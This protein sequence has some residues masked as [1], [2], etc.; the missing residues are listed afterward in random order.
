MIG[1][2][3]ALL[4]LSAF[5]LCLYSTACSDLSADEPQP[6]KAI[7][8]EAR[9]SSETKLT[10][11][12]TLVV[13]LGAAGTDDYRSEFQHAA[14]VWAKLAAQRAM[15]LVLIDATSSSDGGLSQRD[16]L[17]NAIA[18]AREQ[19]TTLWL[20]LIGHGTS[21]RGVHKFNLVGPDCSSSDLAEWI[22]DIDRQVIL[23]NCF[24]SSGPFLPE[25]SAANSIIVTA[26]RSGSESN[27]SRFGGYLA[28]SIIDPATDIDHDDEV[29]LLEAFLSA[30]ARTQTF[31]R[32][33]SRLAT[34][35]AM[36]DDNGD[37]FGTGA[38]FYHGTHAVKS[39]QSEK[40]PDGNAARQLILWSKES[41]ARLSL[42]A[43]EQRAAIEAEITMLRTSKPSPPTDAYWNELERL[44]LKLAAVYE[45]D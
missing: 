43:E 19:K 21:E 35:H 8:A 15:Q 38:E 2:K 29:S 39:A 23:L 42:Q 7:A 5:C 45:L 1:K 18:S 32:E 4:A 17:R 11:S 41:A 27:Y 10:L 9:G 28:D 13:V 22:K 25:L 16:Q 30:S 37:K 20:V 14:Q 12:S 34:E 31:Y 40:Q 24:S 44:L 6:S 26:T 3:F 36:L 33:E